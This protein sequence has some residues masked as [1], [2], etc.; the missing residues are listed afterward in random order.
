MYKQ[1]ISALFEKLNKLLI[2]NQGYDPNFNLMTFEAQSCL[3]LSEFTCAT[4]V[5]YDFYRTQMIANC[6]AECPLECSQ[7]E[8]SVTPMISSFP[9][10]SFLYNMLSTSD[11]L[12]STY[13]NST[14]ATF[15]TVML[16]N[17][18]N[19]VPSLDVIEASLKG[20]LAFLNIYYADLVFT[21]ID[22]K[23]KYSAVDLTAAIGGTL[24]I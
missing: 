16:T 13:F 9:Q 7:I 5:F 10:R 21:K 20:K 2:F 14:A 4:G 24:V 17:Q 11:F 1:N 12:A 6:S 15:Q 22:E 3:K 8:Y 18:T 19:L 23:P